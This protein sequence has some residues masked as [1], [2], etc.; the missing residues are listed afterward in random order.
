MIK[1]NLYLPGR[2]RVPV[3]IKTREEA[4]KLGGKVMLS[5]DFETGE[6]KWDKEWMDKMG[7][8]KLELNKDTFLEA[9]KNNRTQAG[10]IKELGISV[11]SF[12]KY[13]KIWEKEV[14]E[15]MKNIFTE[16]LDSTDAG[17]APKPEPEE[18]HE[19]TMAETE[20]FFG[21]STIFNPEEPKKKEGKRVNVLEAFDMMRQA[22]EEN[23]CVTRIFDQIMPVTP[24][25][26]QLL[27]K[28]R[29]ETAV[30]VDE[31]EQKL[32]EL[33]ITI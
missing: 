8:A 29:N 7:T 18:I 10:A 19:P 20:S 9:I 28:Y 17:S 23:Y 15:L 21:E 13:K 2:A 11:G 14:E 30:I 3:P 22:R 25:V 27:A 26:R 6:T 1:G 32:G 5:V 31:I 33:I 12:Y 16:I 24:A 4:D